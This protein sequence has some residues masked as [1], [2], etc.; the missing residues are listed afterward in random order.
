LQFGGVIGSVFVRDVVTRMVPKRR[1]RSGVLPRKIPAVYAGPRPDRPV[2]G[3]VAMI[4]I[5]ISA[6]AFE[7]IART[8]PLGNVTC[9]LYSL[10]ARRRSN[11]QWLRRSFPAKPTI[12][13]LQPAYIIAT[14]GSRT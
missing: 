4:R 7:A 10:A 8:L 14:G 3:R 9:A 11:S 1:D 12:L 13:I 6:E 5:A 2:L